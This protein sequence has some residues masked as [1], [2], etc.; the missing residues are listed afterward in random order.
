M[1]IRKNIESNA[2]G[3]SDGKNQMSR[4]IEEIK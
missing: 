2:Y 4:D 1:K 3:N